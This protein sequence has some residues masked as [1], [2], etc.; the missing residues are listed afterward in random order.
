M[1]NIGGCFYNE[2]L[3]LLHLAGHTSTT[4]PIYVNHTFRQAIYFD[5]TKTLSTEAVLSGLDKTATNI[6]HLFNLGNELFESVIGDT[7]GYYS[8]EIESNLEDR[9]QAAYDIHRLLHA[10]FEEN[11]SVIF[12]CHNDNFMLSIAGFGGEVVLSDWYDRRFDFVKLS[13]MIDISEFPFDSAADFISEFIYK[14][15]RN[16]FFHTTPMGLEIYD[17]LPVHRLDE[18]N[19]PWSKEEIKEFVDD[20]IGKSQT[21]YGYD[22]VAPSKISIV[23]YD[24]IYEELEM[25]SLDLEIDE[26]IPEGLFGD[27]EF[28]DDDTFDEEDELYY[29]DNIK[30]DDVLH[31]IPTDILNDPILL[32][33]WLNKN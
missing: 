5:T 4:I 11:Y 27:D 22:Y 12:F 21:E 15:A 25:L 9:S 3:N 32:V 16:Y 8:V 18:T 1:C 24:S 29:S 7:I 26:D 2:A 17:Y 31:D 28:F 19:E 13:E 10:T 14:I 6:S 20:L 33:K 30:N 23:D